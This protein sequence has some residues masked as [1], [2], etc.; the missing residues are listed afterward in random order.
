MKSLT[1]HYQKAVAS[2]LL[3]PNPAQETAVQALEYLIHR[4]T[5]SQ[6]NIRLPW[7][8]KNAEP[9]SIYI[10]GPVGRGKTM[11]MNWCVE[12]LKH[13]RKRVERWHFHAFMLEIHANLRDL[14]L[15]SSDLDNRIEKLADQWI[16]RLDVLCFDEFHVTDVADAM[17]MMPLFT[18]FFDKGLVVITTGNWAPEDLY[19]G[20]LQRQR[21][22]PFIDR[23]KQ[24]MRIINV[25]GDVDYRQSKSQ[26]AGSWLMPLDDESFETFDAAFRDIVGYDAIETH[27]I[28]VGNRSWVIPR[29]SKTVACLDMAQLLNQPLGAA[30]FLALAAR[31]RVLF[32]DNLGA[33]ADDHNERAKRFMVLID[34]LYDH[35]VKLVVRSS[36]AAESLYPK[37]G[38]LA[39][40]FERTQSR[41]REMITA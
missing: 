26:K 16:A 34:A 7:S 8:K 11:M 38:K 41:L 40:E 5:S 39:F 21:F 28:H 27:E 13:H 17:I 12:S 37:N 2:G 22:L 30:D 10:F 35:Q 36:V 1:H 18:R 25:T 29:A 15:H 4:L 20:G 14:A 6:N 23:L 19:K 33:F 9:E 24:N 31:Y 32:L 3:W